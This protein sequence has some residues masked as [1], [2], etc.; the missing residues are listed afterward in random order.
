M[1]ITVK[2]T[3]DK[4]ISHAG[5]LLFMENAGNA[6]LTPMVTDEQKVMLASLVWVEINLLAVQLSSYTREMRT[7][8]EGK[9]TGRITF[10]L[11]VTSSQL[12]T[13]ALNMESLLQ[14]V[15]VYRVLARLFGE[16]DC[17]S[18]RRYADAADIARGMFVSRI[19]AAKAGNCRITPH[20]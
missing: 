9:I 3:V 13:I 2:K 11:N 16:N 19:T 7:A 15:V 12:D 8:G 1:T 17:C 6:S 18:S 5:A 20:W 10:E 14:S 4:V